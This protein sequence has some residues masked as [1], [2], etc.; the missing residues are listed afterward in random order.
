MVVLP[1]RADVRDVEREFAVHGPKLGV[2]TTTLD[3]YIDDLWDLHGDGR[4]VIG[5]TVRR[6]ALRRAIEH[7]D[8]EELAGSADGDGLARLL[9]PL[10]ENVCGPESGSIGGKR[11]RHP[12]AAEIAGI[13]AAYRSLIAEARLV[14][15]AEVVE[16]LVDWARP[17][18]FAGPLVANRFSDLTAVQERFLLAVAEHADVFLALPWEEGVL[19]TRALDALVERLVQAGGRVENQPQR[20]Y[21]ESAE[22]RFLEA[23]LFTR[24]ENV[25]DTPRL[26]DVRRSHA[27]GEEA[28]AQRIVAEIQ[29]A[30]AQG[31]P[32]KRIA[33]V[34]ERAIDHAGALRVALGEAGIDGDFDALV[35]ARETGFGRAL[36]QLIAFVLDGD[37]AP[38]LGWLRTPYS[39]LDRDAAERLEARWLME[40]TERPDELR[41][42]LR[43]VNPQVSGLVALA[44]V[45]LGTKAPVEEMVTSNWKKLADLL[46]R[47]AYGDVAGTLDPDGVADASAHRKLLTIASSAARLPGLLAN[48]RD[49]VDAF[50]DGEIA[51]D[52]EARPGAI[53]VMSASRARSQRFDVVIIGGLTAGDFPRPDG[54]NPLRVP[55]LAAALAEVGIELSRKDEQDVA[56]LT[57]YLVASRA[58][59]RLVLSR[60]VASSE[61]R[62]LRASWLLEELLDL[63]RRPEAEDVDEKDLPPATVL[64]FDGQGEEGA[65]PVSTR[66]ELRRAI[67]S[68]CE[69][70]TAETAAAL[71]AAKRCSA[72][73]EPVLRDSR[74]LATLVER[75]VLSVTEI[76]S[77]LRCPYVW[78]HERVIRAEALEPESDAIA[79]GLLCHDALRL[80]YGRLPDA[81]GCAR[82]TPENLEDALDLADLA[83]DELIAREIAPTDF[84]QMLMASE[85]RNRTLGFLRSDATFL[86]G[87]EPFKLEYV[88][89][90][91]DVTFEGFRIRGRIDRIDQ[92]PN[93]ELVV[94]D[95]K[96]GKPG[97]QHSAAKAQESGLL[98]LPLY[99]RI[100]ESMLD[101]PVVAG[102]Y[103]HVN[104]MDPGSTA[105][106]RG[107]YVDQLAGSS[108]LVSTDKIE[109]EGV[110]ALIADAER[111]A[112]EAVVGMRDGRIAP[113]PRDAKTCE[114]CGV[115]GICPGVGA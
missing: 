91:N 46:M 108:G 11:P 22:L 26:G 20:D 66:G 100:A 106:N 39:G 50:L 47:N 73:R 109:A 48:A 29:V 107:F 40:K 34:F 1:S 99:A 70:G 58:T 6:I 115:S 83:L 88:F 105:T 82:V 21:T 65:A 45:A 81:L 36:A 33:V 75:D 84:A 28:E 9:E 25:E 51:V 89:E 114:R 112:S 2:K 74:A 52:S 7:C 60:Q 95:Y 54:E 101:A 87:F 90:A 64:A 19:A 15:R 31:I 96:T 53:R 14:E 13:I 23:H 62:E 24:P 41:A 38:L 18:W 12:A 69:P 79:R 32:A 113:N 80:I 55:E 57:F 27:Y 68:E 103:R 67:S 37:R 17:D 3:G 102:F 111:R 16:H 49:L 42:S 85:V 30:L 77:Y 5:R 71:R 59:K 43:R 76:E 93:G 4:A 35:P 98:Q 61:G 110:A 10:A 8:L 86:P 63:Y 94:V 104:W 56:R 97:S 44:K 78:F 72:P 92:G